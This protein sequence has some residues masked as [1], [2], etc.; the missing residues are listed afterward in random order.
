MHFVH[1]CP[2]CTALPQTFK[3]TPRLQNKGH[4]HVRVGDRAASCCDKMLGS[5][6]PAK[7]RG[8]IPKQL[9]LAQASWAEPLPSR[10]ARGHSGGAD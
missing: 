1:K 3:A 7:A 8:Q 2:S 9:P 5:L 10:V 6:S 4:E